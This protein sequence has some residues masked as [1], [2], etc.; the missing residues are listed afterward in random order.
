MRVAERRA[1]RRPR[2]MTRNW[3]TVRRVSRTHGPTAGCAPA[4]R[5]SRSN[6]TA[7]CV[8]RASRLTCSTANSPLRSSTKSTS[9]ANGLRRASCY[10]KPFQ[11]PKTARATPAINQSPVLRR[12][13]GDERKCRSGTAC[14]KLAT[15]TH[16]HA[17]RP[18]ALKGKQPQPA[19]SPRPPAHHDPLG[20]V[21]RRKRTQ[22]RPCEVR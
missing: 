19:A 18:Q 15:A 11:R 10:A 22:G 20:I 3:A 8:S 12:T 16:K 17:T 4:V 21:T 7:R 9:P 13:R 6:K 5:S 1:K 14:R 2:C